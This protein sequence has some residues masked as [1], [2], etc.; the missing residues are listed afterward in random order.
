M[1]F[2]RV[3]VRISS[4]SLLQNILLNKG[5]T[6]MH[7]CYSPSTNPNPKRNGMFV[8][9]A[10]NCVTNQICKLTSKTI[11][12][13]SLYRRSTISGIPIWDEILPRGI[14]VHITELTQYLVL[15]QSSR[16]RILQYHLYRWHGGMLQRHARKATLTYVARLYKTDSMASTR[17][18]RPCH[19]QG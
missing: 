7:P 2:K 15:Q 4:V 8:H 5:Q 16:S 13:I 6:L 3:L 10:R 14:R 9:R 12:S 18:T 11:H 19:T 1:F 17:G